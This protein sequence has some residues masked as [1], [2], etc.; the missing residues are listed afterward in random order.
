MDPSFSLLLV[1]LVSAEEEE[2]EDVDGSAVFTSSVFTLT[3][4]TALLLLLLVLVLVVS[5]EEEEDAL[6]AS[7][8]ALASADWRLGKENL[9]INTIFYFYFHHTLKISLSINRYPR[10]TIV[11]GCI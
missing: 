1:S 11:C 7:D 3:A 8:D 4:V 6:F 2:E 10:S 5:V 9:S